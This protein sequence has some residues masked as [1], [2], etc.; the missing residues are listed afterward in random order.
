MKFAQWVS[1][2]NTLNAANNMEYSVDDSTCSGGNTTT[3]KNI[4][5]NDSYGPNI[6]IYAIDED[7]LTGGRQIS[8]YVKMKVPVSTPA[9]SYS[10][11]YG[12][13]TQVSPP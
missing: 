3:C 1:G 7:P 5:V 13:R 11:T 4:T 8:L 6:D 12:V 2:S 10:T 9:G